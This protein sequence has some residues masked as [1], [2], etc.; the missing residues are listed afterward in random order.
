MVRA[1]EAKRLLFKGATLAPAEKKVLVNAVPS[2]L[3]LGPST[4]ALGEREYVVGKDPRLTT[5][6]L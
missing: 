1:P 2:Q 5:E 4:T 6:G 3:E